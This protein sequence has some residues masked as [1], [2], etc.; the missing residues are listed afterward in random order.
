MENKKSHRWLW[1]V[2]S[3]IGILLTVCFV[4]APKPSPS[5]QGRTAES[6]MA[7]IF[8]SGATAQS[9]RADLDA[10]NEMGTNGINFLVSTLGQREN[11][12][13]KNYQ[14]I[15][16]RL[17]VTLQN[18]LPRPF[19]A[20]SQISC[21][22]F[23]LGNVRDANP[24]RTFPRLVSLLT[25]PNPQ[26]RRC[27][28]QI[29]SHYVMN[30]QRLDYTSYRP[31]LFRALGSNDDMTL[32]YLITAVRNAKLRGPELTLALQPALSNADSAIRDAARATLD[33]LN[34][35]NKITP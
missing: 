15:H 26:T 21:A 33:S 10:F 32:I 4:N 22:A 29:I 13:Q 18:R 28:A 20:D 27:A 8:A 30:Y 16:H 17:P 7:E 1:L 11:L 12:W 9:Q 6:W 24:A 5:W 25:A 23:V 35:T 34:A 14:R 19:Y 3:I 31:D 2:I